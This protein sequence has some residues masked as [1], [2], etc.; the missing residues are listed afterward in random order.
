MEKQIVSIHIRKDLK[1]DLKDEA[2]KQGRTTNGLIA[3]ILDQYMGN[4]K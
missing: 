2:Q 4:K 3:F 1:Q